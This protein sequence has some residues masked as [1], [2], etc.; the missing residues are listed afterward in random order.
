[1]VETSTEPPLNF[2]KRWDI[3]LDDPVAEVFPMTA[4]ALAKRDAWPSGCAIS[5]RRLVPGQS[6]E[7]RIAKRC[8]VLKG[9]RGACTLSVSDVV[10]DLD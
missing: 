7:C 1:M 8:I 3:P 5:H 10:A 6:G 4:R 2:N 9:P